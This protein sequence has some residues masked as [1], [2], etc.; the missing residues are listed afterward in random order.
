MV[1]GDQSPTID[2][3]RIPRAN[4][5]SECPAS[6]ERW[7]DKGGLS[8]IWQRSTPPLPS[9]TLFTPPLRREQ[10]PHRRKRKGREKAVRETSVHVCVP[11][12]VAL[13]DVWM[14]RGRD[15]RGERSVIVS[16]WWKWNRE[17][18]REAGDNE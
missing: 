7:G 18:E 3:P 6:S 8:L 12:L 17:V 16:W 14:Q 9:P 10:P 2:T 4:P 15:E 13:L 11:R 1:V 5:Y